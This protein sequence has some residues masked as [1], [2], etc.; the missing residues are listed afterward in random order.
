MFDKHMNKI[1]P[2]GMH[3]FKRGYLLLEV[4]AKLLV[5]PKKEKE[6]R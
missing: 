1:S 3:Q 6:K 5:L 4:M 2:F